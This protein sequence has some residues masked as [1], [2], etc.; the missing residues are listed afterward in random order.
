M[1]DFIIWGDEEIH[2]IRELLK[3]VPSVV[4]NYSDVCFELEDAD[5]LC[6]IDIGK[7]L[8]AANIPA[9]YHEGGYWEVSTKGE[10]RE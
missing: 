5:C 7:T 8:A 3:K 6:T 1:C 9:V 4:S 2:T 10:V